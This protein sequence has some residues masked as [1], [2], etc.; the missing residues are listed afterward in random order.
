VCQRLGRSPE[1]AEDLVQ[2]AYVSF[3]EY[4]QGK[5]IRNEEA[6]LSRIVA[7]LA[8]NQ[9]HRE[10]ALAH[11]CERLDAVEEQGELVDDSPEVHR[12]LVAQERLRE[13]EK[14]LT[15][16]SERTCQIFLAHRAGFSY[17]E[18]GYEFG[19]SNRTVQKH[20]VRAT[21]LLG[22]KPAPPSRF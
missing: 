16:V 15:K 9:Y 18:I 1:E 11:L 12:I 21:I 22:T 19:I 17:E 5:Q 6:L 3:L 10:R 2:D 13:V 20:I 4:R 14:T 7:N 8:I